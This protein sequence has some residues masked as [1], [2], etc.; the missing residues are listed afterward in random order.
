M[1]IFGGLSRTSVHEGL[2]SKVVLCNYIKDITFD[3]FNV[4]QSCFF[5]L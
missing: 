1:Q 3:C 4:V 2:F 5:Y